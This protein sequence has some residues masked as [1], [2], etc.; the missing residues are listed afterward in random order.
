MFHAIGVIDLVSD[1][2]CKPHV[3]NRRLGG[4]SLLE[5]VVRRAG[6]AARLDSVIVIAD[7]SSDERQLRRHLP[8]NVPIIHQ[9]DADPL[10]R[11]CTVIDRYPSYGLIRLNAANPFVDATLV[12]RLVATADQHPTCDY[13]SYYSPQ[14][15]LLV[16]SALGVFAE[17]CRADALRTADRL[18]KSPDDR[19]QAM[20]YLY[21]HP[22]RFVSRLLPVP[23]PLDRADLRLTVEHVE[24]WEHLETIFDA[25]GHDRLDWQQ[26]AGFLEHQPELRQRMAALNRRFASV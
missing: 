23:E 14:G 7:E 24:D 13:I 9:A 22:E 8:A 16:L 26:I 4:K 20:R 18:A 11:L 10:G 12:D 17:W 21:S 19:S 15:R 6:E 25:L 5:W 1:D 3:Q 2:S